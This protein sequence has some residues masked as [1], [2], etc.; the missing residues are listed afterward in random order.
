MKTCKTKLPHNQSKVKGSDKQMHDISNAV[1]LIHMQPSLH[2]RVPSHHTLM[3]QPPLKKM[4]APTCQLMC[5]ESQTR[6]NVQLTIHQ[7]SHDT[8][9]NLRSKQAHALTVF[10]TTFGQNSWC[11]W[12]RRTLVLRPPRQS[13]L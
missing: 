8:I 13:W 5:H 4:I 2:N 1:S 11:T 7:T 12:D 10:H 9:V 3:D 6:T